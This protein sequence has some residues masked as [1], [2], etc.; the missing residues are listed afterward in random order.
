M[1]RSAALVL[2]VLLIAGWP[3]FGVP[4]RGD[5][6]LFLVTAR[7]LADG[8]V[9]YRDV[10]DVTNPGTLWFYHLAGTLFGFTEDG[11]RLLEWV[12][13]AAFVGC[14]CEAA[15]RAHRLDRWP[16][17]PAVFVGV[18]YLFT[19]CAR[20]SHLGKTE[21]L[22]GCPL[23]LAAWLAGRAADPGVRAWPRLVA[24]GAAGGAAVLFKLLFAAVVLQV[25]AVALVFVLRRR[26]RRAAVGGVGWLTLGGLL[27]VGPAVGY[28]A[29]HGAVGELA[30]TLIVLPPQFVAEGPPAP[31]GRLTSSVRWFVESHA[32]VLA[33]AV[34]A[35]AARWRLA[36]DPFVPAAV[37]WLAA[38]AAVL[39]AQRL[40]WW[41]YQFLAVGTPAAALAGYGWPAVV[42]EARRLAGPLPRGH[43]LALA[44]AGTCVLLPVLAAGGYGYLELARHRF[45]LT[46]ADRRAC[47]A[48]VGEAYRYAEAEADWAAAAPRPGPVLVLGDPTIHLFSGR[49]PATRVNGW[50]MEL[51]PRA[52]RAEFEAEVRAAR[53][54]YVFWS[55]RL[56]GP[57]F[58][59]EKYPGILAALAADYRL[60][61]ESA[62][63]VWYERRD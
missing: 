15:R 12:Y 10:W 5:E 60:V 4:F 28:F 17:A 20:L 8:A 31:L 23:F 39:L 38:A 9:L 40:S 58:M 32:A 1:V 45:G 44:A 2:L 27:V 63:G 33:A 6:S 46:A 22:A 49:P 51:Y 36:R 59:R 54:V 35:G 47:R 41:S 30:R 56:Y 62:E 37:A 48:G 29:A 50:S 18:V 34:L 57:D 25:W 7:R 43:R 55:R 26:G 21:G 61:R 53:P 14:V 24:A 52:V 19:G 42:A 11:V 13:R 16:V 3:T